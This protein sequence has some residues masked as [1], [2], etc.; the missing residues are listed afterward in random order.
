MTITGVVEGKAADGLFRAIV[1]RITPNAELRKELESAKREIAHLRQ[2]L[3]VKREFERRKSELECLVDDD[4]M[5]R[6]KDG[7]GPYYCPLCLDA[8]GKFVPVP[9]DEGHHYC[10]LHQRYFTTEAR[11]ERRRQKNR[12]YRDQSAERPGWMWR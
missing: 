5:Y 2:E 1:N 4:C 12:Q 9:G 8:D 11:R 6:A 10:S 3:D 7:T